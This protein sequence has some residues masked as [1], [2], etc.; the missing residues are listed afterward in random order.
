MK[1]LVS[2]II[3]T[4]NRS[5][6]IKETLDSISMQTY[7]NWECIIIDDG[8][9]DA[10]EV[11]VNEYCNKDS[12]FIYF[13]RPINKVKG[14]SSC[15][16]YGFSQSKGEFINFVDDDDLL[17]PNKI[18]EQLKRLL[19]EDCEVATT[20][21]TYIKD[22]IQIPFKEHLT[23]K[24][25]AK[26]EDVIQAFGDGYTFFPQHV[27]LVKR[28]LIDRVGLWNELLMNNDDGEF[29]CR[30]LIHTKKVVFCKDSFVLYRE[31]GITNVS[32]IQNSEKAEHLIISLI[33]VH[34]YLILLDKDKFQ[35]Y[36]DHNISHAF[37]KIEER[38]M[39]VIKKYRW[40]FR[41]EIKRRS[42]CF[43]VIKKIK[44]N[45]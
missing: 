16:N 23:Y 8:S 7:S 26:G 28:T 12:R 15:R 42:F 6:L 34:S 14:A 40:F 18:E 21:W 17:S 43:R 1:V 19:Q 13:K 36:I 44:S 22:T 20:R 38:Y 24:D 2:I 45:Y 25:F 30:I 33:L 9:I 27:F 31:P 32:K 29:F 39:P 3:P 37:S 10:T 41:E 11:V 4:F 35:S 5:E